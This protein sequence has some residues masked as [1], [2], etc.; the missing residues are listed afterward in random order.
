MAF[1]INEGNITRKV[2]SCVSRPF[3]LLTI[4]DGA[5]AGFFSHNDVQCYLWSVSLLSGS[6]RFIRQVS[7]LRKINL[8]IMPTLDL[9]HAVITQ[10]S[11]NWS[12]SLNFSSYQL[13]SKQQLYRC[14]V[15]VHV[16][17]KRIVSISLEGP[18]PFTHISH[19]KYIT[20]F[21]LSA[22][23]GNK[24]HMRQRHIFSCLGDAYLDPNIRKS[25]LLYIR[26]AKS[27]TSLPIRIV[28]PEPLFM[29]GWI[30]EIGGRISDCKYFRWGHVYYHNNCKIIRQQSG[31]FLSLISCTFCQELWIYTREYLIINLDI[32]R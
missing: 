23:A 2:S 1:C 11:F 17:A 13:T 21:E 31:D 27:H 24:S 5:H 29:Y 16:P 20:I 3:V 8:L 9:L 10:C 12:N 22:N 6:R 32:N 19:L 15:Q 4:I 28:W 18:T 7:I 26:I 25:L 14:F 30:K